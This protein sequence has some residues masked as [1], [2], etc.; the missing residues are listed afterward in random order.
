MVTQYDMASYEVIAEAETM[1][2]DNTWQ[3][4]PET[5]PRLQTV[6]ETVALEVTQE[7]PMPADLLGLEAALFV[8]LQD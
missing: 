3:L 4:A 8:A 2:S 5:A 6:A 1:A 7:K